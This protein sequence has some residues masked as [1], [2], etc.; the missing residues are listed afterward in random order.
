[1]SNLDNQK[2]L[3]A[4]ESLLLVN[5][6][7][8]GIPQERL[9]AQ[10]QEQFF[11]QQS[12]WCYT[13]QMLPVVMWRSNK[14]QIA[15]MLSCHMHLARLCGAVMR[16]KAVVPTKL[17]SVSQSFVNVMVNRGRFPQGV[18]STKMMPALL[19]R[20]PPSGSVATAVAVV[21]AGAASVAAGVVLPAISLVVACSMRRSSM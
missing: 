20:T 6:T 15:D 19:T 8:V 14:I 9:D 17:K 18:I 10:I 5:E 4:A 16:P 21:A 3:E 7:T 12:R 1:M 13:K 2:T 11:T